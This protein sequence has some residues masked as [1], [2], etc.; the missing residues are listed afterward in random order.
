[1]N[2]CTIPNP[3]DKNWDDMSPTNKGAFC[4]FCQTEVFDLTNAEPEEIIA[5][6]KRAAQK[7][8][9]VK[10]PESK[11]ETANTVN[12]LNNIS[13]KRRISYAFAIAVSMSFSIQ[14]SA[15]EYENQNSL[16]ENS[17]LGG[18]ALSAD[19]TPTVRYD[20]PII[21]GG[22]LLPSPDSTG[23]YPVQLDFKDYYEEDSEM[24]E[25]TPLFNLVLKG[26]TIE[27]DYESPKMY[28]AKFTVYTSNYDSLSQQYV[29]DTIV[30]DTKTIDK[31]KHQLSYKMNLDEIQY[32]SIEIEINGIIRYAHLYPKDHFAD[33]PMWFY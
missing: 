16:D 6:F 20:D 29:N 12:W 30:S 28:Q 3:C 14:S 1:M 23:H 31:G 9:C 33:Y 18:I 13:L 7:K 15:A 32:I 27:F 4:S 8:T 25:E 5:Y 26:D 11:L 10:I 21:L 2:K 24:K 17:I 19:L 22:L